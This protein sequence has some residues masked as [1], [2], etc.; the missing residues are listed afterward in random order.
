MLLCLSVVL[1]MMLVVIVIASGTTMVA[2][3]HIALSVD[4]SNR[5]KGLCSNR[6]GTHWSSC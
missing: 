3:V 2:I 6:A 1:L 4:N 5:R